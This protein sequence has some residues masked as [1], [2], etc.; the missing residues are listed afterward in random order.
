MEQVYEHIRVADKVIDKN[1]LLG[2]V[3]AIGVLI[4]IIIKIL[5]SGMFTGKYV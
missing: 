4:I 2:W 5:D 3:W 1:N